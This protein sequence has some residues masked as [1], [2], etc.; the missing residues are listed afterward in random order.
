M[1]GLL[2]LAGEWLNTQP[3]VQIGGLGLLR[4]FIIALRFRNMGLA[5]TEAYSV[6]QEWAERHRLDWTKD[7]IESVIANVENYHA[8]IAKETAHG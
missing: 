3:R 4:L 2:A 8:E 5:N 6:I 7:E 1:A